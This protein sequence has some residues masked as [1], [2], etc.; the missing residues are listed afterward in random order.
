[1]LAFD[2]R[3]VFGI[4]DHAH[5]AVVV[6]HLAQCPEACAENGVGDVVVGLAER[7]ASRVIVSVDVQEEAG[8]V[9]VLEVY[10]RFLALERLYLVFVAG[11]KHCQCRNHY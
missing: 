1:M 3:G 6:A 4:D 9:A 8:L 11:G 2:S 5:L 7:Y 10:S